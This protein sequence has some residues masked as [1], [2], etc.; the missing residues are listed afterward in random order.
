MVYF[1]L[2]YEPYTIFYYWNNRLFVFVYTQSVSFLS[3][4]IL[5]NFNKPRGFDKYFFFYKWT[6]LRQYLHSLLSYVIVMV[7]CDTFRCVLPETILTFF[8]KDNLTALFSAL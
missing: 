7:C 5:H 4:T 8:L 1:W 2:K 6:P 3:F